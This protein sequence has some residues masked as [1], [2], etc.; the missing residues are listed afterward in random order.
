VL[1]IGLPGFLEHVRQRGLFFALLRSPGPVL[2]RCVLLGYLHAVL[3]GQVLHRLDE[4]HAGVLHQEA[5]GIAVLAAAEAVIELLAGTDRERGRLLAVEGAQP[6]EIG[7]A[8]LQLH[9][10]A[11]D[12]HYV[13][14]GQ[15]LLDERLGD[16][17]RCV[18]L[19]SAATHK[20]DLTSQNT[21]EPGN[22]ETRP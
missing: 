16:G 10:A 3:A 8:L 22:L 14:A 7:S 11:D 5:D 2:R 1:A 18:F 21:V 4:V 12:F 20:K 15:Q 17:H 13:G 6:H 19:P 9:V